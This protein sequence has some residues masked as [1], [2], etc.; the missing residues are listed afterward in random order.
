MSILL[1]SN[2]FLVLTR[3][4]TFLLRAFITSYLK[5]TQLEGVDSAGAAWQSCSLRMEWTD[6]GC[7][8]G[9][10]AVAERLLLVSGYYS[11]VNG[12]SNQIIYNT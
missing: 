5:N 10:M 7:L 8:V 3:F 12:N 6:Q 11:D 4:A 9:G 2:A 1:P